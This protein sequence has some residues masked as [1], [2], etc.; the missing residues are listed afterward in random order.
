MRKLPALILLC[1]LLSGCAAPPAETQP[2]E[3]HGSLTIQCL[4]GGALIRCNEE[5][6][7]VDWGEALP[8]ETLE[9]YK[10]EDAVF[11]GNFEK[12]AEPR[13]FFL[14]CA[15]LTLHVPQENTAALEVTFGET[16]FLFLGDLP[17]GAQQSL[18]ETLGSVNVLY[19]H[20]SIT[21]ARELLSAAY[22]LVDGSADEDLEDRFRVFDTEG[23]GLV[24]AVS[25]GTDVTLS[26]SFAVSD[27]LAV[28]PAP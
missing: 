1:L 12:T 15:R 27:E 25:D 22:L 21:P 10:A 7:L 20:E 16:R 4:D 13:N 5:I 2:P 11:T 17:S 24:T 18:A 9:K 28:A 23:F 6:L 8:P 26:W 3:F 19:F 14:D